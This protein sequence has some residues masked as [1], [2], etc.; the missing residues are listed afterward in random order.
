MLSKLAKL[1]ALLN[2]DENH[3]ALSGIL[4][5]EENNIEDIE[6]TK[7]NDDMEFVL[8]EDKKGVLKVNKFNIEIKRDAKND[9]IEAPSPF[10]PKIPFSMYIVGQVKAGKST[11]LSNILPL[12]MDAFDKVFFISP[13]HNLCPEAINLL[14]TYP[15]IESYGNIE[16]VDV[17]V[18]KMT[19]VNKGKSPNK[20]LKALLI[21]DD[22]IADIKK[23]GRRD[24]NFIKKLALNRRHIG[25]SMIILSQV[26]RECPN[27]I[28]SNQS[29]FAVFRLENQLER[30]KVIEE[31]SGFLGVKKFE[32]LFV[33]ATTDPYSFLSINFDASEK[34][35]Q[36]S[37]NFNEIILTN[38]IIKDK[39]Y[40]FN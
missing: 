26:F 40:I 19:S 17:I 38:D 21:M 31:L 12:Y 22:M 23:Y 13:T 36:Y 11:L 5:R 30:K 1:K 16:A 18:K 28:R 39:E 10:F 2:I 32:K 27:A 24:S 3:I 8:K 9:S 20:K 6:I 34:K 14:D 15:E 25:I 35:Y 33:D 29:S 7:N 37:K 4:Q